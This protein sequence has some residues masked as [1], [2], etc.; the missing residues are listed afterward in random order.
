M[1]TRH[2]EGTLPRK[3]TSGPTL[4]FNTTIPEESPRLVVTLL[5]GYAEY[6]GRYRHVV[7]AWAERGIAT[8]AID[9]RGHGRAE[10]RRGACLHFSEYM[11]DVDELLALTAER[12]PG[13]PRVLFGH[14]FGGLVAATAVL[15][16]PSPWRAL[17]LSSPFF[18]VAAP[19]PPAKLA[20][21]KVISRW[22]PAL[23]SP[24]GLSGKDCTH[25]PVRARAYDEDPLVFKNANSRWFTEA[26][27]AQEAALD[28]AAAI[29]LP[30]FGF[31]G[32]ADP[33]AKYAR[34]KAFF[35]AI[36]ST[37]K[38]WTPH[39]GLYHETLNEIEWRPIADAAAE[40]MLRH[41]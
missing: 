5:H 29:Q 16:D 18:G 11:D 4:Y 35:D 28:R 3:K 34:A 6:G 1:G 27:A 8:V 41:A 15:R 20:V 37:D 7:D 33:I 2:D 12:T 39:E 38:T 22:V 9:L 17:V 24:S 19:V 14:S 13:L 31:M 10:G 40:W 25:D 30:V 23:G 26:A 36:G 21:G 32:T